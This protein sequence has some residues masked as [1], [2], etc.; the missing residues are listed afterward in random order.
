MADLT[1]T[2]YASEAFIG[3]G[4][5]VL[6][7]D[8]ASPEGFEAIAGVVSVTPGDWTTAV[9]DKTHL[10]SP[11][12]HREKLLGLRDSGPF[13]MEMHCRPKHE[14]QANAGGGS[15]SFASGGLISK[16]I[17]RAELNWIIRVKDGSPETELPFVGGITRYQWGEIT[18]EGLVQLTVEVTPLQDFSSQLP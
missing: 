4:A 14:S 13:V 1:G 11:A 2:Y 12:A 6:V 17:D 16:W 9:I 5:E 18:V 3:Y 10:R 8:G 15:G 7:G